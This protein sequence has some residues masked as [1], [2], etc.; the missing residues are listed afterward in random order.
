VP[1]GV[2]TPEDLEAVRQFL[3]DSELP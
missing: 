3:T 1:A 2:D